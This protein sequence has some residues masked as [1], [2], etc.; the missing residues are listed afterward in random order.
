MATNKQFL[1]INE[2]RLLGLLLFSLLA[3]THLGD[4]KT[5]TQSFLIIHFGFFL[6]WQPVLSKQASFNTKQLVILIALV[7]TFI[8]WF[9]PWL[10]VFWT[11]S[12][13]TLLTGRIFARG[14]A[15][16]AYGLAVITLFFE[17]ILNT[18]PELFQLTALSSSLQA[19]FSTIILLLP[20][21]LLFIPVTDTTTKQID[22][23]HGFLVV[24]LAIFLCLSSVLISLTTKQAYIESLAISIIILS[25]FLLFTAIL[26]TPRAG[27]SGLAQIWE[28]YLLNI[29]G[30][31]EQWVTHVSTLEENMSLRPANFL[32]ASLRYL[33]QQHWVCGVSWRTKSDSG[34]SGEKLPI[35]VFANVKN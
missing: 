7:F 1:L 17:L 23:I 16:A 3:A 24:L 8:Y 20:L 21:I 2:H 11:L 15:R 26:W 28:K 9:N 25:L 29:G 13:L 32:S 31:F 12:L 6:L 33:T 30:P 18:T 4:S 22:F 10:N 35:R 14:L 34:F 19:P 5:I 27:F